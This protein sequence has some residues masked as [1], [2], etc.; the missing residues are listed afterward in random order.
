MAHRPSDAQPARR[1]AAP[2]DDGG[3]AEA[4][5]ERLARELPERLRALPRPPPATFVGSDLP[6]VAAALRS[7]RARGLLRGNVFREWGSGLGAV[8]ALASALGYD[9]HGIEIDDALV[10]ASRALLRDLDL[11][12]RI[13]RGS[14]IGP[15]DGD[16]VE[17]CEHTRAYPTDDPYASLGVGRDDPD[18]VFVY[19]WPGEE[20]PHD[21]LFSRHS[22]PG[23]LLLT[24]H[25][26]ARVLVQ[27]RTEDPEE[28]EPLGWIEAPA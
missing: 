10:D 17:G 11:P 18:V 26:T 19:P 9:A 15:E 16:L 14:F 3:P 2:P 23:A 25:E 20:E 8:C 13:A 7:V 21:R 4:L 24:Q 27:R 1:L 6:S 28:L 22:T 12:A 5:L